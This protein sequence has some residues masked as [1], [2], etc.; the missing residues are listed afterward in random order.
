MAILPARKAVAFELKKGQDL[1]IINT[2]G[3]QVVDFWAF[4]SN[5]HDVL[6]M[7]HTRSILGKISLSKGDQLFSTR[8]RVML[9]L[10]ED[11]TCGVHDLLWPACDAERYRMQGYSGCHDNC[12]DNMRAVSP[13]RCTSSR[14][15]LISPDKNKNKRH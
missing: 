6:S 7:S 13:S 14:Q 1:K 9:T 5:D 8:R 11:T 12:T 2:H 15:R 4:D 3:K 10:S